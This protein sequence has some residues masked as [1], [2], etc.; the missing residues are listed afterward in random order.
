MRVLYH[1]R[2]RVPKALEK[3]LAARYVSMERLF[4]ES[5][6]VSLNMPYSP[7][8]HHLIGAKEIA[9]MK[10]TAVIV[11]AARG[12]II[13]DAALVTAL[14]ERRIAAAGL[15]VFEGEPKFNPGFLEVDNVALVPHIGSATRA[16]RTAMA[17]LASKNLSAVLSGKRPPNLLNPE[18]WS[19]RRR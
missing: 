18:V 3:A 1:N 13:D 5:D 7:E 8:S 6:F 4:K 9:A 14:K 12:G 2:R 17:M 11:N 10:P 19:K 16:T 15:D